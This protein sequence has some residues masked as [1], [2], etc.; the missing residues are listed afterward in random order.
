[1][2]AN[3]KGKV[4]AIGA[5]VGSVATLAYMG[6]AGKQTKA[7]EGP[8]SIYKSTS[9]GA[10]LQSGQS[11]ARLDSKEVRSTVQGDRKP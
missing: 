9:Q 7:E 4:L 8:A 10:G 3:P 6:L 5:V 11:D 1:M 2:S